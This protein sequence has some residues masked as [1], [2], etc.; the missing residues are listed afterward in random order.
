MIR[1]KAKKIIDSF[2]WDGK[3]KEIVFSNVKQSIIDKAKYIMLCYKNGESSNNLIDSEEII[4]RINLESTNTN[5]NSEHFINITDYYNENKNSNQNC[6]IIKIYDQNNENSDGK[7]LN[8]IIGEKNKR[9]KISEE[10]N[11]KENINNENEKN[12]END[13]YMNYVGKR[14]NTVL[15]GIDEFDDFLNSYDKVNQQ[16]KTSLIKNNMKNI[17]LNLDGN[18]VSIQHSKNVEL[19]PSHSFD[20]DKF[21]LSNNN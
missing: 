5:S 17:Q 21:K 10:N 1:A 14:R 20:V 13:V 16:L 11:E 4:N 8:Y 15:S 12:D 3:I 18:K 19:K 9:I 6:K 7:K 2:D